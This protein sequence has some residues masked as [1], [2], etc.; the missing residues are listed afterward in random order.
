MFYFTRRC[1]LVQHCALVLEV[2][3]DTQLCQSMLLQ[4]LL[5]QVQGGAPRCPSLVWSKRQTLE[6]RKHEL[7]ARII[8]KYLPFPSF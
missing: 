6:E 2:P 1:N 3:G 8:L 7:H 4:D 5:L